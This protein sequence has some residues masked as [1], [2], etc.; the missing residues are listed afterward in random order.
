MQQLH[1]PHYENR[2]PDLAGGGIGKMATPVLYPKQAGFTMHKY[3]FALVALFLFSLNSFCQTKKYVLYDKMDS[4]DI[5]SHI[6]Q[7]LDTT[8]PG[9][10]VLNGIFKPTKGKYTVYRFVAKYVGSSFTGKLEEFNDLLIVKTDRNRKIIDAFQYTLEWTDNPDI[11]L[12]RSKCRGIYLTDK[13]NISE[14]KFKRA[15]YEESN[16]RQ[17]LDSG[18]VEFK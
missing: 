18:V 14:F 8:F 15:K 11:D 4:A 16:D 10:G 12:Y 13:M 7:R 17:L 3:W 5:K 2:K 9:K 1:K 6:L